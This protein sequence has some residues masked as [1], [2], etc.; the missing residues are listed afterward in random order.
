MMSETTMP[1]VNDEMVDR[2]STSHLPWQLDVVRDAALKT[3]A[4]ALGGSWAVDCRLGGMSG[5]RGPREISHTDGDYA[6]VLLV[7]R[8]R[9]VFTQGGRRAVVGAGTAVIWDGVIPGEC[10]SE[11]PLVK[12]TLFMPRQFCLEALP[13][14]DSLVARPLPSNPSL[15]LLFDWLRTSTNSPDLDEDAAALAGRIA[16]DLLASAIG[17]SSDIVLDTKSIRLMEIKAFI[18][19]RLGD[20]TLTVDDI[21]H[22]NSV[23]T[24]YLHAL[25]EGTGETCREFLMRRRRELAYQLLLSPAPVS[26]TE[27]AHRCGF[28]NPSSFSRAF[29]AAYGV[30]PREARNVRR[31]L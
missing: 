10:Y 12:T 23:S 11:G 6:A 4:A 14:L 5:R 22:G 24:R 1:V 19:T 9:E 8:G 7:R 3:R 20:A 18:E 31:G 27:V 2:F 13:R 16:V 28:D 17:A 29:R 26:V 21:A 25:F 30:S 15:R